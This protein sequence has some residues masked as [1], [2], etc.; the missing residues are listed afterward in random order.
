M[1][2]KPQAVER[3]PQLSP[4]GKKQQLF[5]KLTGL[6]LAYKDM[7]KKNKYEKRAFNFYLVVWN[8][9]SN[10]LFKFQQELFIS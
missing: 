2:P 8:D 3:L 10:Y 7:L 9:Y 4:R 1:K 5:H 6:F